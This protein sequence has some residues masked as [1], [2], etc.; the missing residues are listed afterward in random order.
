MHRSLP[1]LSQRAL[2]GLILIWF[3]SVPLLLRSQAWVDSVCTF[4]QY[5]AGEHAIWLSKLP[6]DTDTDYILGPNDGLIEYFS[7]STA[8]ITAR[9]Y[10]RS[11]ST[12]QWDMVMWLEARRDYNAWTA[13][14]RGTKNGGGGS[15]QPSWIF[16]E[17]DSTRSRLYGVPGTFYAGDSLRLLHNPPNYQYGFQIGVGANDKNGNYGISGW[18]RFD[19]SYS[20]HGDINANLACN[21]LPPCFANID[22]AL[23]QCVSDS[24]FSVA[25]TFSGNDSL[26]S[27]SDQNGNGPGLVPPGSYL[28]GPYPSGSIVSVMIEAQNSDSCFAAWDSLTA[29]CEPVNV[30]DVV[31]DTAFAQC[32]SD[33]SFELVVTFSGIGPAFAIYDDQGSA[34]VVVNQPGTYS[35]GNYVNSV[36]V[37]LFVEEATLPGCLDVWGPLT[38]DCTPVALCDLVFDSLYTEC[39]T[40][41]S[42]RMVVAFSGTGSQFQIFDNVGSQ[43]LLGLSAGTYVYGEYPNGTPVSLTVLDFGI[44]NCFF[45]TP[46]L[47]DSCQSSDSTT[48]LWGNFQASA[49]G[50]VV[51]LT[52]NSLRESSTKTFVVERSTDS[53]TYEVIAQ[54]P[55]GGNSINALRRHEVK[56][57]DVEPNQA[58]YYRLCQIDTLERR[59]FAP[60]RKVQSDLLRAGSF[61]LMYPQ[62]VQ[63]Q[64]SLPVVAA[65]AGATLEIIVVDARGK[66]WSQRS[67]RLQ[68]GSQDI[69]FNWEGLP[70]GLYFVRAVIDGSEASAQRILVWQ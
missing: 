68:K 5:K 25:V 4:T 15:S 41:S 27:L 67:E 65:H 51:Y 8:R 59:R 26:Y 6:T 1:T 35:F 53:L 38:A 49:A 48:S 10:N 45:S 36:E 66:I 29:T 23:A 44:F 24:S 12:R 3:V 14:G 55:G 11:D 52:W 60:V 62:P 20:G 43:P 50:S 54:I 56:D 37:L 46:A 18:F 63:T 22:A 61:G 34:P 13:L 17:L 69:A 31:I 16:Y 21:A 70:P 47:T 58:Y 19:G 28:L 64:S 57:F 42:F 39:A 7:D 2:S 30:C 9:I 32:A 33:S 40:D